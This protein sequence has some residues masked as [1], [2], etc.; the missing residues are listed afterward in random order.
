MPFRN[1]LW[2]SILICLF[3]QTNAFAQVKTEPL[4]QDGI[5]PIYQY[6]HPAK[7]Y[8]GQAK[9]SR[10]IQYDVDFGWFFD[11]FSHV[12]GR[13]D[14]GLWLQGG[15]VTINNRY[16]VNPPSKNVAT[17]DGLNSA[18]F[19]YSNISSASGGCDT[20]TSKKIPLN[21][22]V[23][24]LANSVF[25]SFWWQPGGAHPVMAPDFSDSLVL[26]FWNV[27]AQSWI[28]VWRAFGDTN[29][30]FQY[31]EQP[32][33]S[34]Y[35]NNN[36]QFRFISY[37]SRA[38][39]F[40]IFHIDYLMV[41][42]GRNPNDPSFRDMA[43]FG[44]VPSFIDRYSAIPFRHLVRTDTNQLRPLI[45]AQLRNLNNLR[46]PF[47]ER[48][49]VP[50]LPRVELADD[51]WPYT[52]TVIPAQ[53]INGSQLPFAFY[54]SVK[55]LSI[56]RSLAAVAGNIGTFRTRAPGNIYT[57]YTLRD[58]PVNIVYSNDTLSGTTTLRD[59]YAY[60]DGTPEL[61]RFVGGNNAKGAVRF[62]ARRPDS[63]THISF[64]FPRTVDN[65]NGT[66]SFTLFVMDFL[67]SPTNNFRDSVWFRSSFQIRPG[68]TPFEFSEYTLPVKIP[69]RDTF[70]I[71][72]QQGI[73]PEN[74]VRIGCDVNTSG[75]GN[76]WFSSGRGWAEYKQD[77]FNV[78]V[79]VRFENPIDSLNS[80]P[81]AGLPKQVSS[82]IDL[83]VYPNPTNGLLHLELSELND[84]PYS[85]QLFHSTGKLVQSEQDAIIKTRDLSGLPSGIYYY[86]F[87]QGLNTATGKVMIK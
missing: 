69:V 16:P 21:E 11:D 7:Y 2:I 54:D 80:L 31:V 81:A 4:R 49:I 36:F 77:P 14:T 34:T 57:R 78:M 52:D 39:A 74:E 75:Q 47:L 56:S 55:T 53:Y 87:R 22:V 19:P 76:L 46:K 25:L 48:L 66:V 17:F 38:G 58:E 20:L 6:L 51:Y 35:H 26:Q 84:T 67:G 1:W 73:N 42:Q 29:K 50:F 27:S 30:A 43:Y 71:G 40:D 44:T 85:W 60:D 12:N 62:I 15:G 18:G 10:T 86:K 32:I 5:S 70:F 64:L 33:N 24:S 8:S 65:Q 82:K 63:L 72:W 79:R 45:P 61:V 3:I 13:P 68:A 28:S 83:K 41:N 37:G 23:P 9:S 59:Y